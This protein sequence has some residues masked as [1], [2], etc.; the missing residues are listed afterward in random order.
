M[1]SYTVVVL[2]ALAIALALQLWLLSRQASHVQRYR[3]TVPEAFRDRIP[4]E[5]HQKAA[6]YTVAKTQLLRIEEIVGTLLILFWTL[7]GGINAVDYFWR[8]T[9]SSPRW[10]GTAFV[11]SIA[12]LMSILDL[13]LA[14][15][16]TFVLEE[17]F[18]FN[19]ITPRIFATDTIKQILLSAL[20]GVPLVWVVLWL[21][22]SAGPAWW[23]YAWTT[24]MGF[25]LI[26][27][28]AYPTFIAPLFNQFTALA[29]EELRARVVALVE[30][31]GFRTDG[32]Y[33]M[34]SSRRSGH[35]N[36]YFTGLGTH[37]R[38][39][40][41]DTLLESLSPIQ[42]EAVLAH[43][44]GHFHHHHVFKRWL[45]IGTMSLT[46]LAILGA[47]IHQPQFY[48]GLGVDTPSPHAAL[49]LFLMVV[50]PFALLVQPLLAYVLRAHEFE[51]DDF[52][53]RTVNEPSALRE[54]LL[55]LYREN[56]STLTP[57]PLYSAFYDS[58]P[59]APIRIARISARDSNEVKE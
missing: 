28:W 29:D 42:V 25:G 12:L 39:V 15:Y 37:K 24:W 51:A 54:A 35:G 47:L 8:T 3:T 45:F 49:I 23:F 41:F 20:F 31:C 34:D 19:R 55:R 9:I 18:G 59:P 2:V 14:L 6:D 5:A 11:V 53:G 57:D 13:P 46:G 48:L 43:E 4:L 17:R 7:G 26:M 10:V 56:A 44:L 32:V 21:M 40:F 36:A 27:T 30:R 50:P 58:H 22:D 52:A 16:R 38:I 1:N 33:V